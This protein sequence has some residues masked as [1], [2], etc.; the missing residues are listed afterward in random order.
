M[1]FYAGEKMPAQASGLSWQNWQTQPLVIWI[2]SPME[3]V[4]PRLRRQRQ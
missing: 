2:K 1:N 3:I 4:G